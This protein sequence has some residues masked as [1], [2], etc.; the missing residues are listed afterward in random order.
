MRRRYGEQL[1]L[2]MNVEDVLKELNVPATV[3]HSDIGSLVGS[4]YD[5]VVVQTFY[6]DQVKKLRKNCS[7]SR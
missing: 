4:N 3:E 5:I 1:D 7:R 2:E 6:A